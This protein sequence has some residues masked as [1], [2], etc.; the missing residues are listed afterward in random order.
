MICYHHFIDNVLNYLHSFI[1]PSKTQ[2]DYSF[3]PLLEEK[4]TQNQWRFIDEHISYLENRKIVRIETM[5][6]TC[7]KLAGQMR[8]NLYPE[9]NH[10]I[11]H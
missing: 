3:F 4:Q 5:Q 6:L 8:T 1:D 10:V 7:R 11:D 2:A 9:K